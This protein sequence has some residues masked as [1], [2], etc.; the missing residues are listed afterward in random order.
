MFGAKFLD[1]SHFLGLNHSGGK[2]N[3]Q[4]YSGSEKHNLL[5]GQPVFDKPKYQAVTFPPTNT[6]ERVH[7]YDANDSRCPFRTSS[8]LA[9]KGRCQF[10]W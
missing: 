6:E 10:L 7:L 2:Y 1:P 9:H 3:V 8:V 4:S 5:G